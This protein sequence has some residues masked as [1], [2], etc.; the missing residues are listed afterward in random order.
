MSKNTLSAYE[1]IEQQLTILNISA[2][3][4]LTGYEI[5]GS[6]ISQYMYV[7]AIRN[8]LNFS[9]Q[10]IDACIDSLAAKEKKDYVQKFAKTYIPTD[11]RLSDL[12]CTAEDSEDY[13]C[14]VDSVML[15]FGW[16]VKRKML[17]DASKPVQEHI[18][19]ILSGTQRCGKSTFVAKIVDTL[20]AFLTMTGNMNIIGDDRALYSTVNRYIINFDELDA[21]T[22]QDATTIKRI[23]T[24]STES[25][26]QLGS[27]KVQMLRNCMTCIGT[28]NGSIFSLINDVSGMRRYVELNISQIGWE[29]SN[30][31][32]YAAWWAGIDVN[33]S[34][35]ILPYIDYLKGVNAPQISNPLEDWIST[36]NITEGFVSDLNLSYQTW[37]AAHRVAKKQI[38]QNMTQFGTA[39]NA[40]GTKHRKQFG[41]YW[42]ADAEKVSK[43][44]AANTVAL[45]K[46]P[47]SYARAPVVAPVAVK[48]AT[49]I[50]VAVKPSGLARFSMHNPIDEMEPDT[51]LVTDKIIN[52]DLCNEW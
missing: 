7:E 33:M 38:L 6:T 47:A 48:T 16:Q 49:A 32:N 11:V 46:A 31:F 23:I 28:T 39:I 35:P 20:P 10:Q 27:N 24:S 29:A 21:A 9:Q 26:R 51:M 4:S 25:I 44:G 50:S 52:D 15:Q 3:A 34:A 8:K 13:R 36:S 18:F 5:D 37:C 1:F 12:L 22:K 19:P 45:P 42:T 17:N 2:T 43:I 40:Y 41:M 14:F 30:K